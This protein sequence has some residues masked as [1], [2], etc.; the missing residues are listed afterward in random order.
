MLIAAPERSPVDFPGVGKVKAGEPLLRNY[1]VVARDVRFIRGGEVAYAALRMACPRGRTWRAGTASG[2]IDVAV[3][4]RTV[5]KKRSV[6]VMASFDTTETARRSDRGGHGLRALP[7][8]LGVVTSDSRHW[9]RPA[10]A[11][12]SGTVPQ[13]GW[14]RSLAS[15]RCEDP[16]SSPQ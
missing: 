2:D 12:E 9:E 5:S 6:L 15:S 7:L 14:G 8:S 3:L 16:S 4:D 13:S 10:A 1:V 11:D